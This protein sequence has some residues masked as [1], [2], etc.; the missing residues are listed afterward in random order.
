MAREAETSGPK[1]RQGV[2]GRTLHL[3]KGRAQVLECRSRNGHIVYEES[4]EGEMQETVFD[5][6]I[7]N[8]E[9][10]EIVDVMAVDVV[11][12][13]TNKFQITLGSG[14]GASC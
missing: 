4:D 11:V 9:H 10:F 13:P 5:G 14:A 8:V 6:T 7:W 3:Q 2:P 1:E 12:A